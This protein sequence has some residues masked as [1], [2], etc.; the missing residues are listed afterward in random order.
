MNKKV[1]K[2]SEKIL[3]TFDN[4]KNVILVGNNR[5]K[6]K[7]GEKSNSRYLVTVYFREFE[8]V[9]FKKRIWMKTGIFTRN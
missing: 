2:I 4:A 1:L 7:S 5:G 8:F 6:L 3:T 9:H